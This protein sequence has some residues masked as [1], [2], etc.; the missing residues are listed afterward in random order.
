MTAADLADLNGLLARVAAVRA[1]AGD[2][3]DKSII[4]DE[5]LADGDAPDIKP[6]LGWLTRMCGAL[7]LALAICAPPPPSDE[8]CHFGPP[9]TY[10]DAAASGAGG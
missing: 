8:A 1:K 6:L 2:R 4:T 9:F 7:A 5:I 10:C 3:R